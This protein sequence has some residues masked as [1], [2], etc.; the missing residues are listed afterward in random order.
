MS[1]TLAPVEAARTVASQH[2]TGLSTAATVVL[3]WI[4][5]SLG[6]DLPADVAVAIVLLVSVAVSAVTPRR[7]ANVLVTVDPETHLPDPAE[8][9][10]TS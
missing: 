2:P 10:A 3:L 6:L 8:P 7:V 9:E 1:A 4:A 5:S